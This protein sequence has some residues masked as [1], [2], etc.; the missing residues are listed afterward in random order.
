[1]PNMR[2]TKNPMPS[3]DP[4]VR[5]K[6]FQ[7]GRAGLYRRNGAG[8]STALP[9]LQEHAL[10]HGLPGQCAY[11]GLH[12]KD[13]RGRLRGARIR[14][15][16]SPLLPAGGLRPCLPAGDA[17]RRQVRARHQGRTGRHRPSGAF[18]CRLAITH[19]A[20]VATQSAA[21][22]NGH[23]VAVIGSGPAGLTCAG[24]LAKLGYDVTDLRSAAPCRRRAGVRHPGVPSAEVASCRRKS[25]TSRRSASRWRPTWLSVVS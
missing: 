4:N 21:P 19:T 7:R 13:R 22:K 24:D 11:S 25:I 20:T 5:D 17:V 9:E 6:N 10:R 14:S 1:M 12:R 23:K 2:L 18:C 3:Q 8:R 16:R 15:S